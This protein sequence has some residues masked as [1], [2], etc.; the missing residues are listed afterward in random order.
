MM[1][2]NKLI[3]SYYFSRG[4]KPVLPHHPPMGDRGKQYT[5]PDTH[6]EQITYGG[7]KQEKGLRKR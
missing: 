1:F 5:R 2:L 4:R 3:N 6:R 7:K